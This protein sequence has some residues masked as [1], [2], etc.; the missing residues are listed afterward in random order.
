M[1]VSV[2]VSV[3][4]CVCVCMSRFYLTIV[5]AVLLYG[6]DSWTINNSNMKRLESFHKRATRYMTGKHIRNINDSWEYPDHE[7]LL[8]DCR[9]FPIS[10]YIQRRRGT[11]REYFMKYREE[12][13]NET[14]STSRHCHAA[15]KILWWNQSWIQ[16]SDL[17]NL[18]RLWFPQ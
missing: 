17:N 18:A 1:C 13:L 11:L 16:K 4:V 6:A 9:L 7:K 15:N 10:T 8:K 14:E 12:L 3:C 2:S 5:Q